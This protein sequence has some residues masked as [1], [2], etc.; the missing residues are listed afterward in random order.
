MKE[1]QNDNQKGILRQDDRTVSRRTSEDLMS[2]GGEKDFVCGE[3]RQ[4]GCIMKEA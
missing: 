2:V 3:E 4:W 1:D